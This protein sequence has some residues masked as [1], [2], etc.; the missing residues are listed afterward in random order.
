M[1]SH[2]CAL[3]GVLSRR[4]ASIAY[5]FC[6]EGSNSR[7][8]SSFTQ[9]LALMRRRCACCVGVLPAPRRA[10]SAYHFVG[11]TLAGIGL[12]G[13]EE[14]H[15]ISGSIRKLLHSTSQQSRQL[16]PRA[17]KACWGHFQVERLRFV[18]AKRLVE[19]SDSSFL[20]KLSRPL[21]APAVL[22]LPPHRRQCSGHQWRWRVRAI[23][24]SGLMRPFSPMLQSP[25]SWHGSPCSLFKLSTPTPTEGDERR[26][27]GLHS[28]R[29]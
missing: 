12:K 15:R 14:N 7:L 29:A 13:T 8:Y 27:S 5:W 6:F 20:E 23:T 25:C 28:W 19:S 3:Q 1:V 16:W 9:R 2:S 26:S 18:E 10:F 22:V 11:S 17:Q 24:I 4:F 21:M